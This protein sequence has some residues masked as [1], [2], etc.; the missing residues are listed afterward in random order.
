MA[1]NPVTAVIPVDAVGALRR[2]DS[3][4]TYFRHLEQWRIHSEVY[5]AQRRA[6]E[7]RAKQE[8]VDGEFARMLRAEGKGDA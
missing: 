6:R 7:E 4:S 8:A 2:V 5:A 1:R 3:G